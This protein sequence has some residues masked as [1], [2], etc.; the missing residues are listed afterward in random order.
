MSDRPPDSI[1]DPDRKRAQVKW[2][3]R[4]SSVFLILAGT[5]MLLGWLPRRA[6][7]HDGLD[8]AWLLV[9]FGLFNL[10]AYLPFLTWLGNRRRDGQ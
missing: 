1:A 7:K 3:V 5:A 2:A 9:G 10:F 8:P 4:I 6:V